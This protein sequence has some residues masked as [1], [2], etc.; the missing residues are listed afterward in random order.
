MT[1][2]PGPLS[3]FAFIASLGSAPVLAKDTS[4]DTAAPMTA[5]DLATMPRV[6]APVASANGRF[7]AHSVTQTDP[8]KFERSTSYFILNLMNEGAKPVPLDLGGKASDVTFAA[9]GFLYFLSA[10]SVGDEEAGNTQ[11]WRVAAE[12]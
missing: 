1:I 7:A 6:G 5:Q 4:T 2:K 3:F 12:K 8:A 9:G 11:L 10:R